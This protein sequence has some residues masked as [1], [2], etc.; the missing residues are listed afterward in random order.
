MAVLAS[1]G[2]HAQELYTTSGG[3]I[4][5]WDA[6]TGSEVATTTDA[7]LDS[8][9]NAETPIDVSLDGDTLYVTSQDNATGIATVSSYNATTLATENTDV[10]SYTDT[11]L[12]PN[13]TTNIGTITSTAFSNGTLYVLSNEG[14]YGA[15]SIEAV[16]V[17]TGASSVLTYSQYDWMTGL[18]IDNGTIY[19]SGYISGNVYS[20]DQTTGAVTNSDLI[21]LE[22]A[23]GGW[24]TGGF[25]ASSGDLLYVEDWGDGDT[26]DLVPG[27]DLTYAQLTTPGTIGVYNTDGTLINE[28]FIPQNGQTP[29]GITIADGTLYVSYGDGETIEYN[30]S[31]G[32]EIGVITGLSA[33]PSLATADEGLFGDGPPPPID[34]GLPEGSSTPSSTPEPK[35]I[36]FALAVLVAVVAIRRKSKSEST[37]VGFGAATA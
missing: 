27:S 35:S 36:G 15:T 17:S 28:F 34:T 30:D 24:G 11:I 31:T 22:G 7:V 4:Q 32:A 21:S 23:I 12:D 37:S 16:N 14:W 29:E 26:T 3:I 25:I 20:I 5:E 13:G 18:T 2:A 33:N 10:A 19:T 9:G 6:S 1:Q 8:S